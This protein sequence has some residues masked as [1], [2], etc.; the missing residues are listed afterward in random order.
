MPLSQ[1]AEYNT[2]KG[3]STDKGYSVNSETRTHE[4]RKLMITMLEQKIRL[5]ARQLY[6]ERGEVEGLALE[7]WTK[8]ESEVLRT[9]ILAPLWNV[10]QDF[11]SSDPQSTDPQSTDV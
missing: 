6:E 11:Q 2:C 5:R 9:S 3:I 8:A 1:F 10:R 4:R 7:D